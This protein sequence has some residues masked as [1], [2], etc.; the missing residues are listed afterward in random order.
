MIATFSEGSYVSIRFEPEWMSEA[1]HLSL[2]FKVKY[3]SDS[4]AIYPNCYYNFC[5]FVYPFFIQTSQVDKSV[6]LSTFTPFSNDLMQIS[7]DNS[8][9]KLYVKIGNSETILY[10][11]EG[12]NDNRWHT[13]KVLREGL[14][15]IFQVDFNEPSTGKTLLNKK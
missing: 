8:Q 3:L 14:R 10:S 2:R 4:S 7:I 9:I 13:I 1:E 6:L 15:L 11:K 5:L 12:M